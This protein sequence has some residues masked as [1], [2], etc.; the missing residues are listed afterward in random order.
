MQGYATNATGTSMAGT[1][2]V[3]GVT[4]DFDSTTKFEDTNESN[5]EENIMV[6]SEITALITAI[7]P[8]TPQLIKIQDNKIDGNPLGT[9][10]EIDIE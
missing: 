3:L 9:A 10:D 7:S 5:T 2:T 8:T 6:N 4:F 1:I